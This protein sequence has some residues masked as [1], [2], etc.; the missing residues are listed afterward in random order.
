MVAD[1]IVDLQK[2]L[3]P[4]LSKVDLVPAYFALLKDSEA[5]VKT[6]AAHKVKGMIYK[7]VIWQVNKLSFCCDF[8]N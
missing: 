5:E 1:K 6:A 3:G 4:E 2:A 7:L 8:T